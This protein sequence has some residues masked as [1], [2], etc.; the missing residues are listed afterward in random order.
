MAPWQQDFLASTIVLAAEQGAPGAAEV[1]TWQT[2]FLAGRFLAG[3]RGF[4]PYDGVTYNMYTFRETQDSPLQTW[5]E[6]SVATTEHG[7]SGGGKK[8]PPTSGSY[9]QAAT[10][11][12]GGIV[13]VAGSAEALRA[14]DWL[15]QNAQSEAPRKEL[16][17]D[18]TWNIIPLS[19][20]PMPRRGSPAQQLH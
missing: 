1:L 14:L 20:P 3:D 12:L 13:T 11:V 10:G 19:V 17:L 15:N 18:P 5:H 8:W 9:I 4:P 2:N 6:I 7:M 16:L